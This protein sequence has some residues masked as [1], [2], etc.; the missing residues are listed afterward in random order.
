MRD[1]LETHKLLPKDIGVTAPT[2]MILPMSPEQ[3]ME[4]QKIAETFRKA[5]I[6]CAVD[7]STKKI[8]KKISTAS[9]TGVRYILVVGEDEVASQTFT[10]KELKTKTENSGPVSDLIK[11]ISQ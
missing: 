11:L 5:G 8:Q 10:L 4:S 6:S 3:N 9:E 2:V 7:I 1:F